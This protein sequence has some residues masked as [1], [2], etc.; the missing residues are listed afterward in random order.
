MGVALLHGVSVVVVGA[1]VGAVVGGRI[2]AAVGAAASLPP[3]WRY[4]AALRA[5]RPYMPDASGRALAV[6]D[7][8]WA[9]PTTFAGAWFLLL[10]E[11]RGNRI[12]AGRSSGAGLVHLCDQAIP[13]YATTV[14]VVTA[15]C[16]PRVEAHERVH[17]LQ[18][19]LFGPL[20]LPLVGLGW[21]VATLLPYWLLRPRARAAVTSVRTYFVRGVYPH[22]WHEWWAYRVA[23]TR[24]RVSR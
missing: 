17:V 14:G 3:A 5:C 13:G 9:G 24:A 10:L 16:S 6:L 19:R 18:A 23:P 4:V 21:V 15:G 2:G 11:A 22:T 1:V 12:D 8:T 20:Y 7:A